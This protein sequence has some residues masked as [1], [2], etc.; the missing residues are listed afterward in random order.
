VVIIIIVDMIIVIDIIIVV[1]VFVFFK[2]CVAHRLPFK[3][4][5]AM[6]YAVIIML[7]LCIIIIIVC[8]GTVFSLF[9]QVLDWTVYYS[10]NVGVTT[11]MLVSGEPLVGWGNFIIIIIIYLMPLLFIIKP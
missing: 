1:I 9:T 8:L 5:R 2:I 10:E 4:D 11:V 6:F 3:Y 7:L